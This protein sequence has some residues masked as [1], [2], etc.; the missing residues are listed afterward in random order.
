M[1]PL[2]S[3]GTSRSQSNTN[4]S[5]SVALSLFDANGNE[6]AVRADPDHPIELII[7]R[8][9]NRVIPPMTLQNVTP[10]ADSPHRQLFNLHFI[11]ITSQLPI[12]VHFEM[13]PLNPTLAYLIIYRF[14]TTPQ[15]NSSINLIDGWTSFCP[16]RLSKN[17]VYTHFIDNQQTVGHQSVIFGLREVDAINCSTSNR[18]SIKDERSNFSA[19][20]ELRVYTSGCYYLDRNNQ[21]QGD[22]LVVGSLTN[23]EQTQCFSTHLTTFAAGFV[24][25]PASVNWNYVFANTGIAKNKTIDI[26]LIVICI[27]YTLLLIHVRVKEK[28]VRRYRPWMGA[29]PVPAKLGQSK[30]RQRKEKYDQQ[31]R[32]NTFPTRWISCWKP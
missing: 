6:V 5:T 2:A 13:R 3:A 28:K 24:V 14:D 17:G 23:H 8:D 29:T 27:L 9:P 19:N 12:S 31:I 32:S 11:N 7:P 20:Y 15:L 18:P 30:E 10:L 21:W 26:T 16:S 1:Q 25:L 22:G 4:L